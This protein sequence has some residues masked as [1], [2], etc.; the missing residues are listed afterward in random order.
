MTD[1][2]F[3]TCCV[4]CVYM[5]K[6][7]R[8]TYKR[9]I[10]ARSRN[11][12]CRGKAI[13]ITYSECVFVALVMQHAKRMR[14]I[15]LSSVACLVLPYFSTLSYKRQD[16]REKKLLNVKC[17]FWFPVQLLSETFLILSRIQRD[18]IINVHMS[19]CKVP[20]LLSDFNETWIFSTDFRKILKKSNLMKIRPVR[21]ELLH[22][23]EQTY[24]QTWW[25]W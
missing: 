3:M 20:L 14:C 4:D 22:A 18:I 6:Q 15:I 8:H 16:F 12:C 7:G 9:S 2:W 24:R 13:S 11:H 19:L 17:V 10:E 1:K 23:D 5:H 25:N 21:G